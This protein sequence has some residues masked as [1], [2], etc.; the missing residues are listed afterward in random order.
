MRTYKC[1]LCRATFNLDDQ[2]MA[3]PDADRGRCASCTRTYLRHR[4]TEAEAR[5]NRVIEKCVELHATFDRQLRHASKA[6]H[7]EAVGLRGDRIGIVL[8]IESAL[9]PGA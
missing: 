9:K 8:T 2:Q 4:L 7:T 3:E 1:E 5:L 6:G